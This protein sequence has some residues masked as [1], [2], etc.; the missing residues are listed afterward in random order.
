MNPET[1]AF[2]SRG[3]RE[4]QQRCQTE[5][6][7][8]RFYRTQ[9]LDH[10]NAAMRDF[11]GRQEMLFVATA[12][13]EGECDSSFRAGPAGFIQVFD[14]KTLAYPE[15]RG[16]G[17]MASLGNITDNPHVG[18]LM[19]DFVHDLVGLHINGTAEIVEDAVVRNAYGLPEPDLR[20]RQAELWVRITVVEAYIHCAKHIPRMGK[21]PRIRKWG[22]D[23]G[24]RKKSDYF[25]TTDEDTGG[26]AECA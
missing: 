13:A 16:N 9:M 3:E 15:Y 2:G 10:L 26:A 21:L 4:L 23:D 24:R 12:D 18:L 25:G 22:T 14:D 6:R 17:V 11:V 5:S 19:I 20:G 1:D 7:A 8:T